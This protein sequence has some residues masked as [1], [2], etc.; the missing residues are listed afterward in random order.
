MTKR[1]KMLQGETGRWPAGGTYH[2]R[3]GQ[4]YDVPAK[5]AD[6]WVK[7]GLAVL[8]KPPQ[9]ETKQTRREEE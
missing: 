7:Q 8:V 2:C 5:I 4:E 1:V 9:K 6:A 3:A